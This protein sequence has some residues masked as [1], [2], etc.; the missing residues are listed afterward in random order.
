MV[1][2]MHLGDAR[3]MVS[4]YQ[5][6]GSKFTLVMLAGHRRSSLLLL[7]LRVKLDVLLCY[8]L[9]ENQLGSAIYLEILAFCNALLRLSTRTINNALLLP[10]TPW[11]S[12]IKSRTKQSWRSVQLVYCSTELM[13]ADALTKEL[14]QEKFTAFVNAMML[15]DRRLEQRGRLEEHEAS[16][17]FRARTQIRIDLW[18]KSIH[19]CESMLDSNKLSF[20]HDKIDPAADKSSPNTVSIWPWNRATEAGAPIVIP[21][22][23]QVPLLGPLRSNKS[24]GTALL[25]EVRLSNLHRREKRWDTRIRIHQLLDG[26]HRLV[27]DLEHGV[28]SPEVQCSSF[29][30]YFC[31][32]HLAMKNENTHLGSFRFFNLPLDAMSAISSRR[33][34]LS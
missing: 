21:S 22:K 18:Q 23:C 33:I 20:S 26:R 15:E 27:D 24:Q 2:V 5:V 7:F 6:T 31:P 17:S 9:C 19:A 11:S 25:L 16:R 32:L 4:L 10:R 13:L 8:L 28:Q 12:M 1:I 14:A 3:M 30:P 34:C 29:L